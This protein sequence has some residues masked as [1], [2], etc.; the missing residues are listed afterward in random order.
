MRQFGV[1]VPAHAYDVGRCAREPLHGL[2]QAGRLDDVR[3]LRSGSVQRRC[4]AAGRWRCNRAQVETGERIARRGGTG[5]T[6]CQMPRCIALPVFALAADLGDLHAAMA[7]GKRSE[8][9][10]CLDRLELLGI[11]DEHDLRTTLLG[12]GDNALHLARADH[13]GLVD[14]PD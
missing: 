12:F 7:F 3:W 6:D 5:V 11:A 9:S 10:A 4:D 2:V 14:D 13:P 1:A 8:R